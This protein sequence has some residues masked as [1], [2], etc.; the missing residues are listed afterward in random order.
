MSV[1]GSLS[2]DV[3]QLCGQLSRQVDSRTAA[4]LR[5][6]ARGLAAP[7][8]LAVAGRVSSGKS[9]LVNALIGRRVAP[10]GISECTRLVTRFCYGTVDRIEV[11]FRTGRR[12]GMPLD[13]AG[14][15][16]SELG[17]DLADV[18]AVSH[19]EAYLTNAV[20][21]DL[22]VVDT[23]GL[24]SPD[25]GPDASMAAV[26]AAEAVLYV[27]T[28]SVRADDA[29]VLAAFTAATAGRVGAVNAIAV[30]NKADTVA[31]ESVPGSQGDVG[32]AAALLAARQAE[33][34]GPRVADVLPVVGLLAETAETGVFSTADADALR[35]LAG[36]DPAIRS[37]MV[38]SAD[39][40]TTLPC[41]LP[42]GT[43]TRLLQR[44][45]LYGVSRALAALD[46]NP[47][48]SAGALRRLLRESSGLD[49][50]HARLGSV[51]RA[52]ADAIKA[53]AACASITG[54]IRGCPD[55]RHRAAM[56]G[57]VETLLARPEAHQLRLIEVLTQVGTGAVP[58]PADLADEV[59]R[60]GR[61]GTVAER[62]GLLGRPSAELAACALERA[63]WWRAFAGSGATPAQ[64]RVA[65]VVH[66]T[67][68]LL[69]QQ[70]RE[71]GDRV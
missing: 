53:A 52:R 67:Y 34:L 39:L 46:A 1:P 57:A 15:I 55:P 25:A 56:H 3:A 49:R 21:R 33:I 41:P 51:F 30:L 48:C 13:A 16:P 60:L 5:E 54:L 45:D 8:Q 6:V 69:W 42:A 32:K 24:G 26:A 71:R 43:R 27:V 14:M 9:T 19:L 50:L 63:G 2:A 11:V 17:L 47:Q 38:L 70:L 35:V 65:H 31:A 61:A 18:S 29:Q 68:F 20:L 28:Q 58:M 62:L 37:A 66:R 59:V 36:T 12:Q 44:L 64:A 23:P 10:T 7:L 22:T 4:G 40:F